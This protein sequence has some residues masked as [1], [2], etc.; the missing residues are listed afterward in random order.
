[1]SAFLNSFFH[2]SFAD[3][4]PTIY[5]PTKTTPIYF[6]QNIA[7]KRFPEL[8]RKLCRTLQ[9]VESYWKNELVESGFEDLRDFPQHV[10]E[11]EKLALLTKGMEGIDV[12]IIMPTKDVSAYLSDL[13]LEMYTD[14]TSANIRFEVFAVD[15]GSTDGT[16]QILRKFATEHSSNFYLL[17]S[18]TGSGA[19]R[20][21][22][23]VIKGL[24][25]GE[26]VYFVDA[27][28][29]F[30]FVALAKATRTAKETGAD[31]LIL[32]YKIEYV[33]SNYSTTKG[34]MK[35]DARIWDD[36]MTKHDSSNSDL[37]LAALGLINYPWKQL[38]ASALIHNKGIFF[39]PTQVQNDVQFHWT[40]IAAA[41]NMQFYNQSTCICTH[42]LFDSNVRTQLTQVHSSSRLSMMDA[43]GM[44]QR[45]LAQQGA[46][47]S[48]EGEQIFEVYKTFFKIVT[49]WAEVSRLG[50]V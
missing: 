34:M 11:D 40:S 23:Q 43:L 4:L 10:C 46:F 35:A 20:A 17:E 19:G 37:K 13:L 12:S 42:R 21:R 24:I 16:L 31:L 39:G 3:S 22:N 45:A 25:E 29:T 28:D 15:D 14:L 30:D 32:P 5:S 1:M 38:T 6:D 48:E 49:K 36:I 47:D 9:D 8:H 27:D 26:Y 41:Q 18:G 2:P 50:T 33:H 44:T 7:D